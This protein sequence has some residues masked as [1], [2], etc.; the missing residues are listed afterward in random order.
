MWTGVSGIF[1]DTPAFSPN[2][3]TSHR[4]FWLSTLSPYLYLNHFSFSRWWFETGVSI[5]LWL[6]LLLKAHTINQEAGSSGCRHIRII[7][8]VLFIRSFVSSRFRPTVNCARGG[9][10]RLMLIQVGCGEWKKNGRRK[11]YKKVRDKRMLQMLQW[12]WCQSLDSKKSF[13][14]F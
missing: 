12:D 14:D 3:E 6:Y 8:T 13:Q 11:D 4:I 1:N 9:L 7:P 5:A 2:W 10:G